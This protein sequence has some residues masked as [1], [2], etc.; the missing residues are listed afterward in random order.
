V[1]LAE[2]RLSAAGRPTDARKRAWAA[3]KECASD[4]T[5]APLEDGAVGPEKCSWPGEFCFAERA[6][7]DLTNAGTGA[8]GA[9]HEVGRGL[10]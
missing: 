2:Q 3:V 1:A 6:A 10:R 5:A 9:L 7:V 8:R 4:A